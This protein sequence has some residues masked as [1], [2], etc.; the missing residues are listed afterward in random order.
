[1][2]GRSTALTVGLSLPL[3]LACAP[4]FVKNV[5]GGVGYSIF[6]VEAVPKPGTALVGGQTTAF[7]VTVR[8][9]LDVAQ[10]GHISMVF[11]DQ[12]DRILLPGRSQVMQAVARGSGRTTVADTVQIPEGTRYVHLFV[13]IVPDGMV[14]TS[15]EVLIT[16]PVGSVH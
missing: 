1:M 13:P 12:D 3:V 16:Y 2:T 9:H 6:Y 14:H 11:E 7:S 10:R 4:S 5:G 8:Y 15:G